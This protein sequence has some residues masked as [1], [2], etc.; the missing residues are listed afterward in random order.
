M[1]RRAVVRFNSTL[2]VEPS[3]ARPNGDKGKSRR[4]G[5]R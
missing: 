5:D 4:P 3:P 2:R 1:F